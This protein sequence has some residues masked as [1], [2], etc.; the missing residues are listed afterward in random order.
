MG[1]VPGLKASELMLSSGG[2]VTS[3]SFMGLWVPVAAVVAW[4]KMPALLVAAPKPLLVPNMA[5]GGGTEK[6]VETLRARVATT[7]LAG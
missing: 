3:K 4:P 5:P 1:R 6:G 7:V 2:L